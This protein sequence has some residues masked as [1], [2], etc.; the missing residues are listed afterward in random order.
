MTEGALQELT[1]RVQAYDRCWVEGRPRDIAPFLHPHVVFTGPR[2]E[3]LLRGADA[4]VQS[5]VDF[6]AQ[7]KVHGFSA[8]D[9]AVDVIENTAVMTYRW[10]IDYEFSG[11][12]SVEHGQDVLVWVRDGD[13]WLIA[14][15]S[16]QPDPPPRT[17]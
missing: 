15:R 3:R 6:L 13:R 10:T 8:S 5:Y 4:C 16:Q 1:E 7:A 17:A 12:R 11:A 9:Y 14:W 2:F